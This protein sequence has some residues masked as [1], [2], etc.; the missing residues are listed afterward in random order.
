MSKQYIDGTISCEL[1]END[2]EENIG[3][4]TVNFIQVIQNP[5]IDTFKIESNMKGNL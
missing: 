4:G 1:P 2:P 3:Y 5:S